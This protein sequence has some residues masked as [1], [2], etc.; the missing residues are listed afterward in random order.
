ML[1]DMFGNIFL[2][3][4]SVF[5]H[6]EANKT[7]LEAIGNIKKRKLGDIDSKVTPSVSLRSRPKRVHARD[8]IFLMEQ[9]KY[10][11]HSNILFKGYCS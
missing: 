8:L 11:K 1:S 10:L 5:R 2:T 6:E 9:E 7:A 4:C 3:L